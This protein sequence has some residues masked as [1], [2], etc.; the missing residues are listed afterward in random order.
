MEGN[1]PGEASR[2]LLNDYARK[3][4]FTGFIQMGELK[5]PAKYN[6]T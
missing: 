5:I 2:F 4:L 1:F 6:L 3:R